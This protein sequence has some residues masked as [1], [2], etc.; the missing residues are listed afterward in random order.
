VFH[1][2]KYAVFLKPWC[3]CCCNKLYKHTWWAMMHNMQYH[4][5]FFLE[6]HITKCE[7]HPLCINRFIHFFQRN[8]HD[9]HSLCI[10]IFSLL[11]ELRCKLSVKNSYEKW[12]IS[13]A[14]APEDKFSGNVYCN[15]YALEFSHFHMNF[16]ITNFH[17]NFCNKVSIW[18][19]C[20][21]A[22][23][24]NLHIVV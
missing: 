7:N 5:M 14:S 4:K 17:L 2:P 21:C 11:Q 16:Y 24:Q 22:S 20:K 19:N 12:Q 9:A 15:A 10:N 8:W 3:I 13:I 23:F 6:K 1:K 18:I